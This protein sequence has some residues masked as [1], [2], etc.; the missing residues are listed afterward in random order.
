MKGKNMLM[1]RALLICTEAILAVSI[2]GCAPKIVSSEGGVYQGSKL[3][4]VSDKNMDMVYEA[5]LQAMG[6]LELKVVDKAKDAFGAK[7]EAKSSD[8]KKI[9]VEIKPTQDKKT[10]Y[11]IQVGTLGNEERSQMIF[12]E[13]NKSLMGQK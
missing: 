2:I 5:A 4:A 3:Y 9:V 12:M 11:N 10:M 6:K 13:M 8:D 7:V 1:K